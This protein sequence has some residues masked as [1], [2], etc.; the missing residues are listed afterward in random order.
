MIT[1]AIFTL[2]VAHPGIFLSQK[3]VMEKEPYIYL[4][5]I[6]SRKANA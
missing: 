4:D 2:N 6:K 3:K 1:L 5:P